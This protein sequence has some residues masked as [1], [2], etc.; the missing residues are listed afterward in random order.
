MDE[1]RIQALVAK[2]K[3]IKARKRKLATEERRAKRREEEKKENLDKAMR[4]RSLRAKEYRKII[5]YR[6][7]VERTK[8]NRKRA[9]RKLRRKRI[10][11]RYYIRHVKRPRIRRRIH[12]GDELGRFVIFFTKNQ[13]RYSTY[14]W[15]D[16]KLPCFK[17]YKELIEKN[18]EDM[19]CPIVY[20]ANA[21]KKNA[22]IDK[23]EILIKKKVDPEKENNE[24]TFR[25]EFGSSVTIKTDDPEWLIISKDVWYVEEDFYL[26]GYH[27]KYDRKNAKWVIDN[28]IMKNVSDYNMCAIFMWKRYLIFDND[29]DFTFLVTKSNSETVRLYNI[30]YD[31]FNDV[32]GLYFMGNIA[33]SSVRKWLDKIQEKTGWSEHTVKSCTPEL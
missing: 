1:E 13:Q 28:V 8:K 29:N 14:A 17:A 9:N 3:A 23:Y 10:N 19:V 18:R 15:Y 16:W 22:R 31:R 30:L 7:H 12:K 4:G 27:P 21:T 33:K 20:G 6:L 11:H 32:E 24:S 25:D 2:Y 5:K 26:Y